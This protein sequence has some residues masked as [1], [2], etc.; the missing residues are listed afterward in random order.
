MKKFLIIFI[1]VLVVLIILGLIGKNG[2]SSKP[3]MSKDKKWIGMVQ[4]YGKQVAR[5]M[6]SLGAYFKNYRNT[7]EWQKTV[8]GKI[9]SAKVS[10]D[11][12]K[13][14]KPISAKTEKLYNTYRPGLDLYDKALNE[15][16]KAIKTNDSGLIDRAASDLNKGQQIISRVKL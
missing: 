3:A 10:I 1:L 12:M 2:S 4:I 14:F 11:A 13:T 15:L 8:Q 6:S 5:D 16:E 7:T 9:D